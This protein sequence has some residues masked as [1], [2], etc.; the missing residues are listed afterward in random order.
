MTS[1]RL[2]YNDDEYIDGLLDSSPAIIDAIYRH[3]AKKVSSFILQRGGNKKDAAHIFEVALNDIYDYARRH[4]IELTTRFEPF[5]M[6][7]CKIEW[8]KE[9]QKRGMDVAAESE[10]ERAALDNTHLRYVQ[11][12]VNNGE[13]KRHWL[14]LFLQLTTTCQ[15]TI[16][17]AVITPPADG[18]GTNPQPT[19]GLLPDTFSSCMSTLLKHNGLPGGREVFPGDYEQVALYVMQGLP[20]TQKQSFETR[21]QENYNLRE[22]VQTGR[23]AV[24]W[25]RRALTADN[26][27]REL[28]QVLVDMR[29]RWF[30]SQ[31]K[32]MNRMGLYVSG[33]TVLAVIMAGLLFISPFRKDVYRQ[34]A[35]TEMAHHHLPDNDTSKL[36]HEAA[37]HFNKRRFTSAVEVLNRVLQ[38]DPSNTYARYYRGVCL[39][40]INQMVPARTDLKQVYESNSPYRYDAAFYLALSYLRER[41]K[42]QSLEWLLKIP[43]DAP[44]YWKA[45][46]LIEEIR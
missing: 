14:H 21:L 2:L 30:Y 36:L 6:L 5:F 23:D 24:E 7:I 31:N 26:T 39:V 37:Q 34:F 9:L 15:T 42:Q 4:N 45:K 19:A 20:E 28:T 46:K 13:R 17:N 16:Q 11:E 12:L 32:D 22:A 35:P 1:T 38:M 33:I 40:D 44:N 27:R 18:A 43:Q 3:F 25:L 10:P 41:D 29:Q 8:R